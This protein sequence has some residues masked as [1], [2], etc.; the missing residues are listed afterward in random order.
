MKRRPINCPA[1]AR[2][3]YRICRRYV[4]PLPAATIS[5]PPP[6]PPYTLPYKRQW[7]VHSGWVIC[8]LLATLLFYHM[9]FGHI[10][11]MVDCFAQRPRSHR[12]WARPPSR[13]EDWMWRLWEPVHSD[14]M[15]FRKI[16]M[17]WATLYLTTAI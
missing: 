12:R 14:N 16:D 4:R 11:V 7:M 9:L 5:Y 2:N 3:L 17:S 13:I 15:K 6:S 10:E 8:F 1:V